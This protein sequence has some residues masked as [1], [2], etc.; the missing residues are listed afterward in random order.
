[1]LSCSW[2]LRSRRFG[3][4]PPTAAA[5]FPPPGPHRGSLKADRAYSISKFRPSPNFLTLYLHI[6]QITDEKHLVPYI[7]TFSYYDL[8]TVS[9]WGG[10]G[11][12]KPLKIFLNHSFP[13]KLGEGLWKVLKLP[14]TQGKGE[15]PM[16]GATYYYIYDDP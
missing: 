6:L 8:E 15:S 4:L 12:P 5:G 7:H 1:M 10:V 3:E 13:R 14:F 16:P 9:Q 11:S 2:A